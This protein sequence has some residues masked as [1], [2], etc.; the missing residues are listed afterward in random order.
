[1]VGQSSRTTSA[2][3]ATSSGRLLARQRTSPAFTADLLLGAIQT[4]GGTSCAASGASGKP[5]RSTTVELAGTAPPRSRRSSS[6][7]D[8]RRCRKRRRRRRGPWCGWRRCRCRSC[9]PWARRRRCCCPRRCGAGALPAGGIAPP[10]GEAVFANP[11]TAR[12]FSL[13]GGVDFAAHSDDFDL[14][15]LFAQ[16]GAL[17]GLPLPV[18]PVLSSTGPPGRVV[19]A[20]PGQVWHRR[21]ILRPLQREVYTR[22]TVCR[23]P[24]VGQLGDDSAAV[25]PDGDTN[26][27]IVVLVLAHFSIAPL[28]SI[29]DQEQEPDWG[30]AF[31]DLGGAETLPQS[32]VLLKLA[33][34]HFGFDGF[35]SAS[36]GGERARAALGPLAAAGFGAVGGLPLQQPAPAAADDA[37]TGRLLRMEQ[38]LGGEYGVLRTPHPC[39]RPTPAPGLA[40]P[41]S[42]VRARQDP[43]ASR[44][45]R[46]LAALAA[47][48]ASGGPEFRYRQQRHR[49]T[50]GIA[51]EPP[52]PGSERRG[53]LPAPAGID[54]RRRP[55]RRRGGA[56]LRGGSSAGAV[57]PQ[58]V[59]G[60]SI[61]GCSASGALSVYVLAT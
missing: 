18:V 26:A 35:V 19:V 14:A 27:T 25:P 34:D 9:R 3:S 40:V 60:T 53:P 17:A 21:V 10:G 16:S 49:E 8:G 48:L 44:G 55:R 29:I 22:C 43:G 58:P 11:A 30:A 37:V 4:L 23:C 46:D 7:S 15:V 13:E 52:S 42:C 36:S 5:S 28:F 61:D 39:H 12:P 54:A 41:R 20:L 33:Q 45:R 47:S 2:P 24:C 32:R 31:L 57:L 38:A 6:G 50:D 1:M 59:A 56:C 51:P